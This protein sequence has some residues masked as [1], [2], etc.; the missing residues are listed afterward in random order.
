MTRR[1]FS[2][3][4]L[5]GAACGSACSPRNRDILVRLRSMCE[6]G[7]FAIVGA[8]LGMDYSSNSPVPGAMTAD[9]ADSG[10]LEL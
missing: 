5:A 6:T 9:G 10:Q 8:R 1:Q 7:D 3:F 4:L 2:R